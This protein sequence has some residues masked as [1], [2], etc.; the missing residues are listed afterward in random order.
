VAINP[1]TNKVYVANF[2]SSIVT[3]IDGLTNDTTLVSAG[4]GPCAVTVNPVTNKVYVANNGTANVTVIDGATDKTT[5]VPAGS[6]PCAVAVNPVT[7]RIYVAN[8]GGAG[9]TVIDEVPESDTK[10]WAVVS[11]TPG[12]TVVLARP[13]LSGKGVN[14]W[15]LAATRIEGVLTGL[16]SAQR[17]WTWAQI[18]GGIGT[19]SVSWDYNWG[20]DSLILGENF[21]LCVALE[22]DVSIMNNLGPGTP[23]AGNLTVYP[24]YRMGHHGA[25]EERTDAKRRMTTG[26]TLVRGVLSLPPT[27]S[28]MHRASCVLLD[29]S[30]RRVLDLRPGANDVRALAPGV[31]FIRSE[32]SAVGGL[33]SAVNKVIVTE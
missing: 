4:S 29:I 22:S 25:V 15:A 27:S 6:G 28:V 33:P 3:V 16:N 30:G 13:S 12:D 5:S 1:V 24:L 8:N 11:A 23:F 2:G 17:F 32:P 21:V 19:D 31:Y 9:V 20:T 18:T 14:R 26:P 10:V 7:N